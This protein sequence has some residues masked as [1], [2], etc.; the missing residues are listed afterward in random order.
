MKE[1][2]TLIEQLPIYQHFLK[3]AS[4][5][6]RQMI[7]QNV[8]KCAP[9]LDRIYKAFPTYT[10]HNIQHQVNIL[11]I[12]GE[13][14]GDDLQH[15]SSLE[16]A[17]LILATFYHDIGMVF[18]EEELKKIKEE[19]SFKEFIENNYR[20]KFDFEKNHQ[21]LTVGL[22]EW[23][24]RW[25]HARRV[26]NFLRD[27][28]LQWGS[29][30]LKSVVGDICESHNESAVYLGDDSKFETDFQRQAD[31]RFCALL[32]RLAD[33][34][35]FD[36]SRSPQSVYEFLELD[37]PK[38]Q[39][40][41]VSRSEWEKH[42][43]SDGFSITRFHGTAQL[44]F[45]AGPKHPE[46]ERNI[47]RF[48]DVIEK[49]IEACN[50][51][52]PKCSIRWRDFKLSPIID[53]K[54][55]RP[56]NYKKGS[57]RLSLDEKQIINLLIGEDLYSSAFEFLRELLQNAID[58]SRMREFHEQYLGEAQF[59]S[60]PIY[61]TSWIDDQGFRW[62]GIDDN[63]M[64][65]ND[66]VV[67]NHLLR[68]GNSFYKSDY[69]KLLQHQYRQKTGRTFTPISRFGI[70]LLSCFMLGDKIEITSKAV[71]LPA[72]NQLQ[73]SIRLSITGLDGDYIL[74]TASD[75][76]QPIPFPS[77][78]GP[79]AHFRK[80]YGTS[81]AVRIKGSQDF[82]GFDDEIK[83]NLTRYVTCSPV[84]IYFKGEKLGVDFSETLKNQF[85]SSKR[86]LFSEKQK[87]ILASELGIIINGEL[88]IE[89]IPINVTK[90]S[91]TPNL[92]G[93]LCLIK[94]V[95]D[96]EEI[97]GVDWSFNISIEG[98]KYIEFSTW[99]KNF[100][101]EEEDTITS[102]I[103]IEKIFDRA[104]CKE[105]LMRIFNS[106][107]EKDNVVEL[108]KKIKLIHNG[109]NVPNNIDPYEEVAGIFFWNCFSF[110]SKNYH[111]LEDTYVV[112]GIIYL[113]DD[114]IPELSVSRNTIKR[115]GFN[116]YSSLYFATRK[117]NE[118]SSS[119]SSFHF[120]WQKESFFSCQEV[121]ND[122]NVANGHWDDIPLIQ[123]QNG[124]RSIAQ[125]KNDTN[126][127]SVDIAHNSYKPF[128][129]ALVHGLLN[130]NFHLQCSYN[131]S[132][133]RYEVTIIGVRSA[134]SYKYHYLNS[135]PVVFLDFDN[136]T[137][138]NYGLFFNKKHWFVKWL[139]DNEQILSGHFER[140]FHQLISAVLGK[141]IEIANSIL[142]HLRRSSLLTI[143]DKDLLKKEIVTVT[144]IFREDY[145]RL[146]F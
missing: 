50:R 75:K 67:E 94:L 23:Y 19:D 42:L 11:R 25:M 107:K 106:E 96:D 6:Q 127:V 38:N 97:E 115:I 31:T 21:E 45:S 145:R 137:I 80:D 56:Q 91:P 34:L 105:D 32:L 63:G 2:Y 90:H 10:L 59:K 48:L 17:L 138:I 37:K 44:S 146:L 13:I 103:S 33:I 136:D 101:T 122:Y 81:I 88:G 83:K 95:Y 27:D 100:E 68:K 52:L 72:V 129:S 99:A 117:L 60:P 118:Y 76:H 58:A 69:F 35:D 15:L 51:M 26:W 82:L 139:L 111:F 22:A 64:G 61:L 36:S 132:R 135:R 71:A 123:T 84:P 121:M 39:L 85:S 134:S 20:A 110:N 93:Q 130:I 133:K 128:I 144:A 108:N 55:I 41:W 109:I 78:K 142:G 66:Y 74:Q 7:A 46:V 113:Q 125:L 87:E 116:I 143:P 77:E 126:R 3:V 1:V 14:L 92:M 119:N 8:G 131:N 47:Q 4:P 53:R 18:T 43:A 49:E 30:S 89:I 16:A 62:V 57:Y 12:M 24:C 79:Q 114:L 120:I 5:Q 9:L 140:Y 73:Q 40:E 29:I 70:G 98:R 102:Q 104:F 65:I 141:E 86:V 28:E 124:M 112:F 54:D